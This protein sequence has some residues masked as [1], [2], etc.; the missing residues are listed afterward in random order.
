MFPNTNTIPCVTSPLSSRDGLLVR[1]TCEIKR[2]ESQVTQFTLRLQRLQDFCGCIRCC[3]QTVVSGNSF[4]P[5]ECDLYWNVHRYETIHTF[6][7]RKKHV[8]QPVYYYYS[9]HF[10]C[11]GT[12]LRRSDRHCCACV[13]GGCRWHWLSTKH[14]PYIVSQPFLDKRGGFSCCKLY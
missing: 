8:R 11:F 13:L 3:I 9:Y 4:L 5:I 14:I 6:F 2:I 7:F 12:D 10:V 1:F